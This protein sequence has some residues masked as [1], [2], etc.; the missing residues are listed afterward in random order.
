MIAKQDEKELS[1]KRVVVSPDGRTQT[2]TMSATD[3]NGQR[4]S[5]VTIWEKQ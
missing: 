3:S 5:V 2:A 4:Y 1:R